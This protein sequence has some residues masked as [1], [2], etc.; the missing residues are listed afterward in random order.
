[1]LFVVRFS[2]EIIIKSRDVRHRNIRVLRRSLRTQSA[3][4]HPDIRVRGDWDSLEVEVPDAD[5]GTQQQVIQ[6][7]ERTPG[8]ALFLLVRKLPLPDLDGVAA[9]TLSHYADLLPGR[10]FA[11][12]CKRTGSHP[13]NSLDVERHVGRYL[14]RACP[15]ARVDLTAPE[16]VVKVEIHH[17]E[18]FVVE[19]S[20]KG[21]G[22]YPLGTQD[23]VL[24]LISGG[25]D[26]SVAS[27]LSM[28]R[29]LVTH[30]CCFRLGGPEHELAVKDVALYLWL[31]Y[32]ASH[33]VKF[34]TVPF[35]AVVDELAAKLEPGLRGV[36]LKR[37]ML[38]AATRL[39]DQLH[40]PALV[41]GECVAQVAS[42]TLANLAVIDQVTDK[43][44]LRPLIVTDKQ[45]IIDIARHIGTE[46]FSRHVP[47]FCGAVSQKPTTRAC[48]QRIAEQEALFDFGVLDAAVKDAQ[49]QMIDRVMESFG[50][51]AP[52]VSR[53]LPTS[54]ATLI[55]IRHPQELDSQALPE[56]LREM[57]LLRIP[58]YELQ[59]RLCTLSPAEHYVLYCAKGVM[60]RLHAAHMQ[61][62]GFASVSVFSPQE[63]PAEEAS[64]RPAASSR[65]KG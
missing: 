60:S 11:V 6:L 63:T 20:F 15:T 50:A 40:I 45:D 42:Q 5:A 52:Q 64:V 62:A 46:E 7:L 39:A 22:G 24:S 13:W 29:G 26:S 28:R 32:G 18:L 53:E 57:P 61:A 38:R 12:R 27:F 3:R 10:R 25:F 23:D 9:H 2:P 34:V 51:P 21:L 36:I 19:G 16:L 55:D 4:I 1:M 14:L 43:V 17:H 49:V 44:L 33:R 59:S 47:E 65:G 31:R 35:E 56:P 54:P 8:I 58:F 48:P 30:F 41:T 37:M